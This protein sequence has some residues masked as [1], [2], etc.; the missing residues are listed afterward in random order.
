MTTR[1]AKKYKGSVIGIYKRYESPRFGILSFYTIPQEKA[2]VKK[3][4]KLFN[5]HKAY[6]YP[7]VC[8]GVLHIQIE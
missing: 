8:V 6:I 5:R 7:A 1:L 4:V 2:E 3:S